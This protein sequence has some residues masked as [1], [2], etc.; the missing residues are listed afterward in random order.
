MY[1]KSVTTVQGCPS[2][3]NEKDKSTNSNKWS[4]HR[5]VI[6]TEHQKATR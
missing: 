1:P 5:V 2:W 3:F 6:A 4:S